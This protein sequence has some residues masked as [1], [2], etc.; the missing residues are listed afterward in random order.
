[1]L[2]SS[3]IAGAVDSFHEIHI[4]VFSF[5]N[6]N[7]YSWGFILHSVRDDEINIEKD[8]IQV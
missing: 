3:I 8:L 6:I 7:Y 5:M 4:F 2:R 1:M